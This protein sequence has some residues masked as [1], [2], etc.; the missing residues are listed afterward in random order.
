MNTAYATT[1]VPIVQSIEEIRVMIMKHGGVGFR[2]TQ[3]LDGITIEW[4]WTKGGQNFLAKL[5]MRFDYKPTHKQFGQWVPLTESQKEQEQRTKVRSLMYYLK[6]TYDAIDKGIVL[7]EQAFMGDL[8]M[9]L[10]NGSTSR[11][12][13]ALLPQIASGQRVNVSQLML[14]EAPEA[15]IVTDPETLRRFRK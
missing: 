13:D 15:E 11:V 4:G 14:A 7:Q 3:V 8:V 10:P 2:Y 9:R 1:K 12:I 5:P 6:A